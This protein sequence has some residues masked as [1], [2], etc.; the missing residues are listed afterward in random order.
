MQHSGATSI[1][2]RIPS[3]SIERF[4]Q[5]LTTTS[6]LLLPII[7]ILGDNAS[8]HLNFYSMSFSSRWPVI[9]PWAPWVAKQTRRLD[10]GRHIYVN[11]Y[12][13]NLFWCMSRYNWRKITFETESHD[14]NWCRNFNEPNFVKDEDF[15][16]RKK[17]KYIY[18]SN[19]KNKCWS[20]LQFYFFLGYFCVHCTSR[21]W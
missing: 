7:L 15:E 3:W 18:E 20:K 14:V 12:R 13:E 8:F 21:S 6:L 10:L 19:Q 11:I 4:W 17:R 5:M 16:K 1:S 9:S 2:L